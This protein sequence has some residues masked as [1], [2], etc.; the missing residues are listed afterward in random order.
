MTKTLKTNRL[1]KFLQ[2]HPLV[3]REDAVTV[4]AAA[5]APSA[6]PV[7][8]K[9]RRSMAKAAR[10]CTNNFPEQ[11]LTKEYKSSISTKG[12]KRDEH[13]KDRRDQSVYDVVEIFSPPR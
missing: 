6:V 3:S 11:H 2:L 12:G 7:S 13:E 4:A 10:S 5:R 1:P 8:K 9:I